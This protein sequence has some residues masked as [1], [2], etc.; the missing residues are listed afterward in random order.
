[1]K[2]NNAKKDFDDTIKYMLKEL[3][4]HMETP[5]TIY[6]PDNTKIKKRKLKKYLKFMKKDMA[7]AWGIK[8]KVLFGK[9][10]RKKK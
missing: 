4:K 3:K 2:D 1:M 5:E 10:L 7:K 6:L 8:K 9:E